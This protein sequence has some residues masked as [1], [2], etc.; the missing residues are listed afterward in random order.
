MENISFPNLD[1][2]SK[3]LPNPGTVT[4]KGKF[5]FVGE[6][7]FFL[8]GVT[9]GTFSLG[10]HGAPFPEKPMVEKDF[11]LMAELGANCI[12]PI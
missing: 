6:K 7:K 3:P 12:E 4:V 10:S 1:C 8:K 9:Y 5:F 2:R 11:A